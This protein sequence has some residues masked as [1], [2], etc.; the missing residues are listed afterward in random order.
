MVLT[1]MNRLD[2]RTGDCGV[3]SDLELK[4]KRFEFTVQDLL[5]VAG[6]PIGS[7]FA[8]SDHH[9]PAPSKLRSS[10]SLYY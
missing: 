2:G 5:L 4:I 8:A 6:I 1:K 7:N 9:L 3:Q 10:N